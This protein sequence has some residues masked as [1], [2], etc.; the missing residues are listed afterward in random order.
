MSPNLETPFDYE[1]VLILDKSLQQKGI[2][3][4]MD[5]ILEDL[6]NV[7]GIAN[8]CQTLKDSQL[9]LMLALPLK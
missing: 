9:V 6:Y 3:Y 1:Q 7:Y 8:K 4:T 2:F 5:V